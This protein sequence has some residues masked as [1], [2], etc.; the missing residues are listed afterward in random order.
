MD[1]IWG[2]IKFIYQCW[3]LSFDKCF[4]N[5]SSRRNRW[6]LS[7]KSLYN[8]YNFSVNLNLFQ[9]KNFIEIGEG[10]RVTEKKNR[11]FYSSFSFLILRIRLSN[12]NYIQ[13]DF[14]YIKVKNKQSYIVVL[15]ARIVTNLEESDSDQKW[16]WG[17]HQASGNFPFLIVEASFMDMCVYIFSLCEN[18]SKG[19]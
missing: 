13:W 17:G 19:T 3:F 7:R 18:S 11:F 4:K 15:K 2:W 10:E 8:F 12:I 9:K 5:V 6:V 14:I 1:E 16:A